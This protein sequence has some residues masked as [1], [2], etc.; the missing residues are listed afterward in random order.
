MAP[1]RILSLDGGGIR[2]LI[3]ALVLAELE[4]R[5]GK[6]TAQLFDLIA[7]TSTGGILALGLTRPGPDGKPLY[8][9]D[10]MVGLYVK[11]GGKIF[12]RPALHRIKALGSLADEKYPSRG[13]DAV[14]KSRFGETM[15][16][17]AVTPVLVTAYDLE[18][19]QPYFFKSQR[20]RSEAPYNHLMRDVAR[21]TSAAPTYFEPAKLSVTDNDKGYVALVDGGVYANNPTAC[22]LVES[23]CSFDQKIDDVVM[24]SLGTGEYTKPIRYEDAKGWGLAKWAQ[25]IL[26]VV[27]DGVSD[28][29]NYQVQSIL[30]K[31]RA[32]RHLRIQPALTD[33]NDAMDDATPDN[34]ANLEG[35]ARKII[36][37]NS[38]ALDAMAAQLTGSVPPPL[39]R[40]D[41][42]VMPP[43]A[44]PETE[45]RVQPPT[46]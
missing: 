22:A 42:P 18:G 15:L 14:L 10:E 35:V 3:P 25:P 2:G 44:K 28:T 38:G 20:A 37:K 40:G 24:L 29:V 11:E 36:A 1:F 27:F 12:D 8:S 32:G 19:R 4:R 45:T 6:R 26:N 21:A 41:V 23:L 7:G 31:T 16:S 17:E 13:I 43:L 9:A 46:V 39:F 34:L 33:E 5:T 30:S